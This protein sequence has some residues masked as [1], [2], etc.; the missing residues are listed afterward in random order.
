MTDNTGLTKPRFFNGGT[1]ADLLKSE[2]NDFVREAELLEVAGLFEGLWQPLPA[3]SL[4]RVRPSLRERWLPQTEAD[5]YQ[6]ADPGDDGAPF[7]VAKNVL[8][9][10]PV[11]V[12]VF[13]HWFH[14]L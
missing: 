5:H 9:E 3:D 12:R 13:P 11:T 4:V 14:S 10:L 1:A 7:Q 8:S 6:K 2:F